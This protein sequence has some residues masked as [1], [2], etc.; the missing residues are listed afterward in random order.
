[1]ES[2]SVVVKGEA[3]VVFEIESPSKLGHQ[4]T[5][6]GT[7]VLQLRS[8]AVNNTLR[9]ICRHAV[10]G[11]RTQGFAPIKERFRA[12]DKSRERGGVEGGEATHAR[13]C[14]RTNQQTHKQTNKHKKATS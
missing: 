13:E 3:M 2:K 14:R 7:L 12:I 1:M 10:A 8:N 11:V 4:Q 9:L 6:L 5:V